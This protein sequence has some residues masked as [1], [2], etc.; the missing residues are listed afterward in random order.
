MAVVLPHPKRQAVMTAS[1]IN[2]LLGIWLIIA[3]FVLAYTEVDAR[4]NDV[5][6]GILIVLM[7][8]SRLMQM[9]VTAPSWVN[10]ILGLWLLIAPFVMAYQSNDAFWN[11]ILVGIAVIAF[12][13]WSASTVETERDVRGRDVGRDVPPNL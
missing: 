7:A 13:L 8:G 3:P 10:V 1:G 4:W 5:I 12:G 6:V 11:N 9:S 2:L